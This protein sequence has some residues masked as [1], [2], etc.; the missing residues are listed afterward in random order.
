MRWV[1]P[2]AETPRGGDIRHIKRFAWRR[3]EVGRFTVWLEHYWIAERFF[4]PAGGG[5]GWWSEE[6]K[7]PKHLFM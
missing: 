3:T 6:R 5:T 7:I 2:Q 1:T 4:A